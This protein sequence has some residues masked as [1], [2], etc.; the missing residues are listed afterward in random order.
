MFFR[1]KHKGVCGEVG[2]GVF[3]F[4]S[5]GFHPNNILAPLVPPT[6]EQ[7]SAVIECFFPTPEEDK[8]RHV[9][10]LLYGNTG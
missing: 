8:T 2:K 1:A 5:V 9:G 6:L 10:D 3:M 7:F 4:I